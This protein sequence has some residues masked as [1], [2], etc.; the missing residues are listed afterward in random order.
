MR[1]FTSSFAV[2]PALVLGLALAALLGGAPSALAQSGASSAAP[3]ATSP[4]ARPS[5]VESIDAI[6]HELYAVISGDSGQ[7]RD[8]DRM[9][10]LFH[11]GAR[12]VPTRPTAGGGAEAHVMTLD[13]WIAG[14]EPY[15]KRTGFHER[16]IGRRVERYG[17]VAHAFSAYES[18]HAVGEAPF[19]RGVN[20]IQLLKDGGRWWVV[21]IFW[22]AERPGNPVP[23]D[24][25]GKR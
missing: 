3:R 15:F 17:N 19:A 1:H 23:E 7:A 13:E 5:D 12:L 16:E 21:T 2:A 24:L 18:L 4:A 22:D 25:I 8:W 6:I 14:A 9:R 10:S 11:P 20:S